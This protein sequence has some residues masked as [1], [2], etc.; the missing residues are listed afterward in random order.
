MVDDGH[1]FSS[2]LV[3]EY[4]FQEGWKLG[5]DLIDNVGPYGFLH[6]PETFTGNFYLIK[7][8]WFATNSAV[9]ISHKRNHIKDS[10]FLNR[11]ESNCQDEYLERVC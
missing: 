2:F 8:F 9:L 10:S 4:A 11:H 6:Y 5:L 1:F 7:T 3:F